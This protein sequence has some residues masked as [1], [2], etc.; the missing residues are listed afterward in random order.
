VDQGW[1]TLVVIV[2]IAAAVALPDLARRWEGTG[3]ISLLLV[4]ASPSPRRRCVR[5]GSGPPCRRQHR[6]RRT[7]SPPPD[8]PGN[9]QSRRPAAAASRRWP[10]AALGR[11][12]PGD[13]GGSAAARRHIDIG[14]GPDE[15]HVVLADRD[16]LTG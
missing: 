6:T 3:S 4:P 13:D 14:Q 2:L 5:G 9:S 15:G 7:P 8:G 11:S 1:A 10:L 12:R 16:G